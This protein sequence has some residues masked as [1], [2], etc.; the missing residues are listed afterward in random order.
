MSDIN[1]KFNH[2]EYVI[3]KAFNLNCEG[4]IIRCI[5]D[6]GMNI[7]SVA[8]ALESRLHREEF[9]EDELEEKQ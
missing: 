3:V 9:Y 8:Y 2:G 6:G 4:R 1:F 5:Y 7:Y